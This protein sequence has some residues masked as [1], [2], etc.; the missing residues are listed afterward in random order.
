MLPPKPPPLQISAE[1]VAAVDRREMTFLHAYQCGLT[2]GSESLAT[3]GSWSWARAG[4]LDGGSGRLQEA[5]TEAR[6]YQLNL[7]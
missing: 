7:H 2:T 1:E 4:R 3:E 6:V 5:V